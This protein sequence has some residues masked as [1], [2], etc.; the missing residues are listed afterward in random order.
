MKHCGCR[1]CGSPW[2]P[3][4]NADDINSNIDDDDDNE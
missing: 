1:N 3:I 4:C 2:F